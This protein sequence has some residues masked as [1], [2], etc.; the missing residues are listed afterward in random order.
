[1][2]PPSEVMAMAHDRIRKMRSLYLSDDEYERI[3]GAAAAEGLSF[4]DFV[5]ALLNRYVQ[6]SPPAPLAARVTLLEERMMA[7]AAHL[8]LKMTDPK[9]PD[10]SVVGEA[11]KTHRT[12]VGGG[13]TQ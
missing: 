2:A 6:P 4:Q 1:M 8:G 9:D 5:R 3:R 10:L 12:R 7:M 13:G 11:P